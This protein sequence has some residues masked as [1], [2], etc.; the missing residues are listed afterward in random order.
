MYRLITY[1]A[2]HANFD[3]SPFCSNTFNRDILLPE[4]IVKNTCHET[5]LLLFESDSQRESGVSAPLG[6]T[7]LWAVVSAQQQSNLL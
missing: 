3:I 4:E 1:A 7:Q 6:Y 5:R 2:K